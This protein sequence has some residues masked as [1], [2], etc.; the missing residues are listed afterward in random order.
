MNSSDFY[1]QGSNRTNAVGIL[2]AFWNTVFPNNGLVSTVEDFSARTLGIDEHLIRVM[3]G[4][5][6]GSE[7]GALR[8]D[9]LE[10]IPVDKVVPVQITGLDGL[11]MNSGAYMGAMS[12]ILRWKIPLSGQYKE[13]PLIVP[14]GGKPLFRGI[15]FNFVNGDILLRANPATFGLKTEVKD[16]DGVPSACWS[17]LL[18]SAVLFN[19]DSVSNFDFYEL[20][21]ESKRELL[22]MLTQEGSK[23]NIIRFI[24]SCVRIKAPTVFEQ[25]D[26]TGRYTTLEATWTEEGRWYGV[27]SGQEVI[28]APEGW[29]METGFSA[30]GNI[31]RASDPL[32]HG[33]AVYDKLSDSDSYGVGSAESFIPNMDADNISSEQNLFGN[34]APF[35]VYNPSGTF[36]TKVTAAIENQGKEVTD[37]FPAVITGNLVEFFYSHAGRQQPSVIS[38]DYK[39]A[40]KLPK[41]ALLAIRDSIPAGSLY[42]VNTKLDMSDDVEISITDDTDVFNVL[43]I[44]DSINFSIT[45]V[46][47]VPIKSAL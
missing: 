14:L 8:V 38:L 11:L 15:D 44:T 16:V 33:I 30:P 28:S 31:I 6:T 17:F 26:S 41:D 23:D 37:L 45:T 20:P 18:A 34:I 32:V 29:S 10:I 35:G 1:K 19:Q 12:P 40:I 9:R 5:L 36:N 22:D 4:W 21:E 25:Y 13:V 42:I 43:D 2:G 46:G 47:V 3:P 39:A 27:T 7:T 24:E